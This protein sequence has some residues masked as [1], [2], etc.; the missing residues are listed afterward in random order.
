M[1]QPKM[2][3]LKNLNWIGKVVGGHYEITEKLGEGGHCQ[4]F[5]GR[6]LLSDGSDAAIKVLLEDEDDPFAS[7]RLHRE[8]IVLSTLKD[9]PASPRL[10]DRHYTD[11]GHLVLVL[12]LLDGMSLQAMLDRGERKLELEEV[13][14]LF[15]P[16]V[17]TLSELHMRGIIHRNIHP[18]KL[19]R[20]WDP[21]GLK[22]L[23]FGDACFVKNQTEAERER[24]CGLPKYVAPEVWLG[25]T[26]L[27]ERADVYSLAVVLYRC[28][29]GRCP[30]ES[31]SSV[32][33]IE[34]VPKAERP[35]LIELRPD[36]PIALDDW[37]S[38]ALCP[39]RSGRFDT[40]EAMWRAFVAASSS[41]SASTAPSA[42]AAGAGTK[43]PSL[44]PQQRL[45]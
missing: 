45:G 42:L 3:H 6:S 25:E 23:G 27:D 20:S 9:M 40:V 17:K 31:E 5:W 19:F 39:D 14:A 34:V 21:P 2:L 36:L 8:G 41:P 29:A 13:I 43:Q 1:P 33:L 15:A 32:E 24:F 26:E 35:S 22:V 10:L 16:V 12:E 44:A 38:I 28:L 37:M 4:L 18:A 11:E 30:F 7:D